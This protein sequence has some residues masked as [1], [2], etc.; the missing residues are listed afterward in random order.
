M[1]K[2]D[3]GLLALPT[4]LLVHIV[5]LL[6]SI[7]DRVKLRYVS[8][9]LQSVVET[10]SLWREFEWLFYDDR[11]E[12]CLNNVLKTCGKYVEHLS[13]PNHVTSSKLVDMLQYCIAVTQ[14]NLPVGTN[15]SPD[16]LRKIL[17]QMTQL[18]LLSIS[19]ENEDIMP[20]LLSAWC[21]SEGT[22]CLFK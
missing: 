1:L 2:M 12:G 19:W 15:F 13:A 3:A 5:S 11:E 6:P 8:H 10:P 22:Y 9:K 21:T 16:Q 20:L 7:R 4:E 14:L 18:Q 17:E